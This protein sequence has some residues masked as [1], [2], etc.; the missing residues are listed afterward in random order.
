MSDVGVLLD[1]KTIDEVA[2][3]A[4]EYSSEF[5]QSL[6]LTA[7][8]CDNRPRFQPGMRFHDLFDCGR[9]VDGDVARSTQPA[10]EVDGDVTTFA[11][12]DQMANSIGIA[13]Q[14]KGAMPGD[15]VALLLERSTFAYASILAVS[16]IG[17]AFVPLDASFPD[18]RIKFICGDSGAQFALSVTKHA[19]RFKDCNVDLVTLDS[20]FRDTDIGS[21]Q[22]ATLN[23]SEL[24][25]DSLAYII[26][27]SGT[28]GNPKGVP[29][30]HSSICNFLIVAAEE[31]GFQ[32]SD[33]VFQSLTIAFD[34]SFEEIWV[35]LLC[36]ACLVPAPSGV[37]LLGDDL[38]EFLLEKKITAWCSVPTVLATIEND[39][40]DLRLL[41]V[42]GEACPP[43][44][45]ERWCTSSRRF[46]N[47]YGP[48]EATVSATWKIMDV[49]AGVT[50]GKPLPTYTAM[51]LA[52]EE[53]EIVV[54]GEEGELALAGIGLSDGYL[55][56]EKETAKAFIDDFIGIENN[57]GG[58]IYRS[59]DLA[60]IDHNG[61]IEYLGRIDTQVKIR[62]YR[63]E[64]GEIESVA[65]SLSD[66]DA[67]VVNPVKSNSGD[68]ELVLYFVDEGQTHQGNAKLQEAMRDRL[69]PYMVPAYYEQIDFLPLLPSQKV[70]RKQLPKPSAKRSMGTGKKF[71]PPSG[72]HETSL[73]NI[74]ASLLNVNEISA[75]ADFFAELGANSLIMA[76][77]LG[78][79]RKNANIKASMKTIYQNTTIQK[80]SAAVLSEELRHSDASRVFIEPMGIDNIIAETADLDTG[81]V[82]PHD[83]KTTNMRV[84]LQSSPNS[85]SHSEQMKTGSQ[86][87]EPRKV[88]TLQYMAFGTAQMAWLVLWIFVL[89]AIGLEV[90]KWLL[91]AES[92]TQIWYRAL[93]SG[94][95]VF[96]G[97]VTLMIAIKWLAVG[98]FKPGAIPVWSVQHFRFWVAR[99]AISANPLVLFTGTP[100]YNVFLRL[101]GAKVGKGTLI[102][103]PPPIATDLIKI[104]SDTV[105]RKHSH[106][107]GYTAR[108]GH[109][110]LG[111]V[112][113]GSRSYLGEA[114]V[115]DINSELGD[116]S[117]LG[118]RSAL[119]EGQKANAHSKYWGSPAVVGETDF[120][121]VPEEKV[122]PWR[123]WV[124]TLGQ[125]AFAAL[126]T[127]PA[128]T[129]GFV[130]LFGIISSAPTVF[131][132]SMTSGI[133]IYYLL[134]FSAGLYLFSIVTGLI[135][136]SNVPKLWN[137]FF[138]PD[139]V[140]KL[141]GL[142]FY[143]SQRILTS[144]SSRYLQMLFGDSSLIVPYFKAV[145]YNLKGLKQNGSNFGVE[146]KHHSPFLCSFSANS[147]VSDGLFMINTDVSR[148]SF[149]VSQISV[150][151]NV[152]L[153]NDLHYPTKAMLGENCLVG[154]KAL[155][156][157]DGDLRENIG[158]LGS[159]PFE[160][161]RSMGADTK[162][163]KFKQEDVLET[164]LA[165]KLK[166]NLMTMGW[167][168][169]RDWFA[170][171][172]ILIVGYWIYSAYD[173]LIFSNTF[174]GGAIIAAFA[175]VSLF[176]IS[177]Y[178]ILF[179]RISNWLC[180]MSPVLC[181]LYE[182]PFWDRERYWKL[183]DDPVRDA[184]FS[185]TPIKNF[186]SWCQGVQIGRQVFDDGCGFSEP[187]LVTI[188]DY[189]T[190]NFQSTAQAHSLE[191]G[192]FKSDKISIG[193]NSTL[194]IDAFIHYGAELGDNTD[195]RTDSFVMKGSCVVDGETWT[196]N[197]A[198]PIEPHQEYLY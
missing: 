195:I 178:N 197:P 50:I 53:D 154:T 68:L 9:P 57:P 106:I 133:S 123:A 139:E 98:K 41:I 187:P 185:G 126:I 75:D 121:R 96:I 138:R 62:G 129:T 156:P 20:V 125:F 146:Q 30:N 124:Y 147:F 127:G 70:D 10:I 25:S 150:P 40:P 172:V 58:K 86:S 134:A 69:P 118:N 18:S 52:L 101:L 81:F 21:R 66:F 184:V 191:D 104:G 2:E 175:M 56:R 100:V 181:S 135:Y 84:D 51:I 141:F 11:M 65:R 90:L 114:T 79:L 55:N 63:I 73:A 158:I 115:M 167:F 92:T 193:N 38:N 32:K 166:S 6:I 142:Q 128:F 182:R 153:G 45:V 80:L 39:L 155:I 89:G 143:L 174:V 95:A 163:D 194:G 198:A 46:L 67:L 164:G 145:G 72:E 157:I 61:E 165:M 5:Q 152:Y 192:I 42:S 91:L 4:P 48:T 87:N 8:N 12:L 176:A 43:D 19:K 44:L 31:Y 113:I 13:L 159:P 160:I 183:N 29:I 119:H 107:R 17:C 64:L 27:T 28:T 16:K 109:L 186:F 112:D 149:K 161:P 110:L 54:H 34:Y 169:L 122:S 36:G 173:D 179:G 33:R 140:H 22:P 144:S 85:L 93:V 15:V 120:I 168:M 77:Y 117:Q 82:K 148:T 105:I 35:P 170:S 131:S 137:V 83:N 1:Q 23:S 189:C 180:P 94:N 188:G 47:I 59:G 136:V 190:L 102:F 151:D 97:S 130:V 132:G 108:N 3:V 7:K 116:G 88:S 111:S 177:F 60:R 49:D 14:Q 99:T 37:N 71:V 74:L 196:A 103:S 76:R 171:F 26:Y 78:S 24:P 162:F